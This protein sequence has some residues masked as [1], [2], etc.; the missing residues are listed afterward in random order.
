[1]TLSDHCEDGLLLAVESDCWDDQHVECQVDVGF[2]KDRELIVR[3]GDAA[4]PVGEVVEHIK[5]AIVNE[6]DH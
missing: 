2:V 1:M 5:E 3:V 4:L 6:D